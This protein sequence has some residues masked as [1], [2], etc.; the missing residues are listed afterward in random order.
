MRF[1]D[2][3]KLVSLFV[4]VGFAGNAG[5][6]ESV[7]VCPSASAA[8]IGTVAERLELH[9]WSNSDAANYY[10]VSER[11]T[12]TCSGTDATD[13]ARYTAGTGFSYTETSAG[14]A[15]NVKLYC[16]ANTADV[17]VNVVEIFE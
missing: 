9:F 16:R 4:L 6:S 5:A 8:E 11:S 12:M 7:L 17:D 2:A 14:P 10:C 1:T 15:A 3:L 13:G